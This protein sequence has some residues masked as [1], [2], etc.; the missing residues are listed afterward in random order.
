MNL[1]KD[2]LTFLV[3]ADTHFGYDP[4]PGSSDHRRDIVQ[5]MAHLPGR[6]Y[7]PEVGGSVDAPRLIIHCGDL[8]NGS[9]DGEVALAGYLQCIQGI[10]IPSFETLGN[11]DN[12][13]PHV[14]D[15]F[16]RKHGSKYYSFDRE[17]IHFICLY[18]TFDKSEK[19]QTLDDEQLL[20]L[21]EDISQAGKPVVIFAHDRLDNLPN[22]EAVDSVLTKANVILMF[23]GHSHLQIKK[24]ASYYKW[25]GRTG[26]ITGHCRNYWNQRV[27]P[28][29][30]RIIMVARI[31]DQE[32][33]C[34]PWRWDLGQWAQH[35]EEKP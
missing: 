26:I 23:S 28:P 12:V 18:Q 25:K 33:V 24:P 19:V 34:V 30:G 8:V 11:H 29:S 14:V 4:Q 1:T 20:W 31:T 32:V 27:D 15:W 7:P 5:Q 13:Y 17:G 16:V 22:A 21:A 35:C 2:N 6:P 10:D 3:W 9:G